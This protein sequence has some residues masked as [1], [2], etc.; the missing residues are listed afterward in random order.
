M[1]RREIMHKIRNEDINKSYKSY[2]IYFCCMTHNMAKKMNFVKLR[3]FGQFRG[4][5]MH[6]R[7]I[8]HKIRNEDIDKSYKLY[9]LCFCCM[10]HNMAKKMNFVKS[11]HF[12]QFRGLNMRL[13]EIMHKI[14]NEDIDKS[15]KSYFICFCCMTHNMA[16]K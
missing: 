2:P 11:R 8:M 12:G 10:T 13:R 5:N 14:R 4:L 15:Y 16:K 1:R 6:W 3:H 7:E 9:F